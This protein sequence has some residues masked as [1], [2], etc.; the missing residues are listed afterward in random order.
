MNILTPTLEQ[1][2]IF[3]N[4]ASSSSSTFLKWQYEAYKAIEWFSKD[5][6]P[7]VF[8]QNTWE[9]FKTLLSV[10][11]MFCITVM[12]YCAVRMFEIRKKEHDHLH[13]E[14]KEYAH[15]M[16]E[17]EKERKKKEQIST[18]PDWVSVI[19]HLSTNSQEEWKMAIIEADVM[20]LKLL[21]QLGFQGE[22]IGEKLK[23]ADP[24]KFKNLPVAW[25]VHTIRNKIVHEGLN[26]TLSSREVN[27]VITL[28]EHIFQEFGFI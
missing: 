16:K 14:I 21:T 12:I 7:F 17:K 20:L 9:V 5:V 24:K 3:G 13:M 11:T 26:F 22:G 10:F 6:I 23:S 28:Y 8:S 1:N 19:N 18:N 2:P 27:R 15:K 4:T 25:E